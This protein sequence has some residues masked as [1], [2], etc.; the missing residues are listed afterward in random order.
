MVRLHLKAP[1]N[2]LMIAHQD[3]ISTIQFVCCVLLANIVLELAKSLRPLVK[4]APSV[5]QLLLK[6]KPASLVHQESIK[7][8]MQQPAT[9]ARY[10]VKEKLR[11]LTKCPVEVVRLVPIKTK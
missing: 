5:L 6:Q 9:V 2:V 10:V 7:M 1:R 4:I 3:L 8:K 11:C